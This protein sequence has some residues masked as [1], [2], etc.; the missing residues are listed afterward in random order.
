MDQLIEFKKYPLT[1]KVL[2]RLLQ[3]KTTKR[4]IIWATDSYK[5][6]GEKYS[7]RFEITRGA[8]KGIDP[9]L[10]QPRAFKD[11]EDQQQRTKSKAE[12]FTPP[13]IINKMIN[14]LDE[15][16]FEQKDIFNQEAG[17]TWTTTKN[18]VPFTKKSWKKY[19][20]L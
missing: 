8:L 18:P 10:I 4:N 5:E 16:W 15:D 9:I 17:Q 7:D 1:S 11:L 14:H 13:W 20:S 2:D 19:S 12:V 3:D 6:L